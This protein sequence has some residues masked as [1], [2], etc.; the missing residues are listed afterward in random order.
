MIG[1]FENTFENGMN[2][3]NDPTLQPKGTYPYMINCSLV[4]Q[5][6]RNYTI[7]DCLGNTFLVAINE[8]Y[9]LV[10]TATGDLPMPILFVS[11]PDKLIVFSTNNNST[12]GYGEIGLIKY[13]PYGEGI[14]AEEIAG[15]RNPGYIPLYSHTDLNFTQLHKADGFSFIENELTQRIYWTD[16]YNSPRVF[17]TSNPIFTT[18]IASGSLSATAGVQY[19]VLQGA[20]EYPVGGGVGAYYGLGLPNGNI[21]TTAG[22]N[23]T[24]TDLT[25][26]NRPALV[27]EYFPVELLDFTPERVLGE[28][29]LNQF[30]TGSVYCGSKV[31]YYR[32]SAAEGIVTS[33]SYGT[34]PIPVG[35][36][37][38]SD[39]LTDPNVA[40]HDWVGGGTSTVL[41]DSGLSVILDV[42]GIDTNFDY[43]EI[44]CAEF[45][46]SEFAPRQITIVAKEEITS[47]SMTITHTGALN[48]G[49]LSTSDITN[50]PAGVDT[51]K[52]LA[53]NKNYLLAG[54]ITEREELNWDGAANITATQIEYPM[55]VHL[56]PSNTA[57][58]CSVAGMVYSGVS[59]LS[60][61]YS[62]TTPAGTITPFSK[63]LVT[64]GSVSYNGTP[65][66]T[67]Q[68]FV[69]VAGVANSDIA[70]IAA[71][72]TF[73]PCVSKNRYNII[74]GSVPVPD[75]IELKR[76]SDLV[77]DCFWDYRSAAVASHVT[78]YW[79]SETYRFAL[80]AFDLKGS[81]FYA[82]HLI[83]FQ[84]NDLVG[85][86]AKTGSLLRRDEIGTTG[87]YVYSLN[88]SGIKFD[89]IIF[90]QEQIDNM[91]GFAIMRAERDA[92]IVAQGLVTQNVD[93]G[94]SPK[95][96]RPGAW[97]PIVCDQYNA[98]EKVY[99]FMCPDALD[100]S[101]LKGTL[102]VI[103]DTMEEAVWLEPKDYGG[104]VINRGQGIAASEQAYVKYL[105]PAGDG[106]IRTGTI[107]YYGSVL[108]SDTLTGMP[109]GATYENDNMHIDAAGGSTVEGECVTG[110]VDYTLDD[111]YATGCKKSVFMLENDFLHYGPSANNYTSVAAMSLVPKI[112]M[113]YVKT[114]YGT[115]YGGTG[116]ASLANTIYFST[117]HYQPINATVKVHT[118]NGAGGYTFNGVE[119]FG[120]DCF[121]CLI[122]Q[123][124]ALWDNGFGGSKY[125]YAWTFPCE[126]NSNYNL[127]RGKKTSTV[128]MYYTGAPANVIANG[129]AALT[130]ASVVNLEDYSYNPGYST[131]G[132][133]AVYPALPVNFV[134]STQ[135]Q[136]RIRFNGQKV[137]GE[138]EDSFRTFGLLDYRDISANYGRINQIK[139]KEDKVVVWQDAAVN[140]VPILERQVVAGQT[141]D[142]T[143]IG[144]GGVIDR[145]DVLSSFFG[146]QHQWSITETEYGFAWF[147]MRRKAFVILDFGGGLQEVSQIFGLKGFFDEV[148]LE[149][150]GVQAH[151]KT[152]LLNSPTFDDTS[153]RPLTGVG[154]ISVYD[155]KFKM[156][157]MT[158]KF[159]GQNYLDLKAK[160]FTIGY[161][162][163]DLKKCFVGFYDFLPSAVH[164]HNGFV[165]M[166]NNPKNTTQYIPTS[167]TL[168]GLSFVEGETIWGAST[169]RQIEYVCILAVTL[170]NAA[171][172]PE[173]AS[174]STYWAAVNEVNQLWVLN[175]PTNT[176]AT[177]A[178]DYVYNKFFGKVVNNRIDI[179]VNPPMSGEES[180]EV[181]SMSQNGPYNINCTDVYIEADSQT[182]SDVS[183]SATNRNYRFIWNKI[184]SS[185]PLSTTGRI[186]NRYLK[187]SL[188]KK[189]WT[190]SPTTV[191][192]S[193]KILR[194]LSSIFNT[195]N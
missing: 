106:S 95:V 67:G 69:G 167:G 68:V 98:A 40:Y 80:V 132:Q 78:G 129:I 127:R 166:A 184:V 2:S 142:A 87:D 52:T 156:T 42:I 160:D 63:W 168:T 83:D 21:I 10:Y 19:M 58:N 61:G 164:N 41:L 3:D 45:D 31:Y 102:G 43:I 195:K 139:V 119:V 85:A 117:G 66:T 150:E 57:T 175:M 4:S 92:R 96:Y 50:F 97:N 108:E 188:R 182:A 161:L 73:V 124:Y 103:G 154:I 46:Q 37:N 27:I 39:D 33:W 111:H 5:D 163:T 72:G 28:I 82:K 1:S 62:A 93:T 131:E 136:A 77:N 112:L 162:H 183:I 105:S 133:S 47:A 9:D 115:P 90:T 49:T 24:Y 44:A 75:Y 84:F 104:G 190:T 7:K 158:F 148:F 134:N 70:T 25:T 170:D 141:G 110:G 155:P 48:L 99:T 91:S 12:G 15:E 189:N 71:S 30:G 145:W 55:N 121:T 11:F 191:S 94:A 53:T 109:S 151:D 79:S 123:G 74:T 23:V 60:G 185:L 13:L 135:F 14:R 173:G 8:P 140:T 118:D 177:T 186:V 126:C 35:T 64:S 122:D 169:Y 81:P 152:L 18:Y 56:D 144:T 171:K 179:I 137:I 86:S 89:G 128:E 116:D 165:F 187:I 101:P 194:S 54:N 38:N 29:S 143:T 16:N 178:P 59:P 6:G 107:S 193:V 36:L 146:T 120:G 17:N 20:I 34:A 113:N 147:D 174:G 65:Y 172:F 153:D 130:A 114:G 138:T 76:T 159:M 149:I 176:A 181:Q 192:T 88:P 51:I 22:G 100:D 125:S 157:Y 32:L 180:F 26:P